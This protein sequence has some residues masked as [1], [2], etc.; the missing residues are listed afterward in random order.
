MPARWAGPEQAGGIRNR[1]RAIGAPGS[2]AAMNLRDYLTDT[3]G[4]DW[5]RLLS[6]WAWL[7]P[8]RLR[9]WVM[10]RFGDV[11]FIYPDGTVGV[12]AVDRGVVQK[13][14]ASREEFCEDLDRPG[15]ADSWLMIPLVDRAVAAG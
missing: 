9:P 14:A 8:E 15:N 3:G 11:F 6:A 7:L 13:A 1:S 5:P 10:N 12:L 2:R 4:F